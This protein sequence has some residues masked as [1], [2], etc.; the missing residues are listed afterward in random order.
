MFFDTKELE[1]VNIF[2]KGKVYRNSSVQ[3]LVEQ[4]LIRQEGKLNHA[5]ALAVKTGRYT[6]RAAKAR[7][8]VE[9]KHKNE[10]NWGKI[11]K[12]ISEKVFD[13]LYQK[14]AKHLSERDALFV[15]D[16]YAGADRS[17]SINVR[18]INEIAAQ[19]LCARN[20]FL[21]Y[22]RE[23]LEN[24]EPDFTLLV[25]PSCKADPNIDGVDTNAF[26][27]INLS[28]K[29]IL[30]GGTAYAGEMK[31]SIF[32]VMNY[33]MPKKE[34]LPMHCAANM[35]H[36]GNVAL[37]FGL[38]GTGKTTLSTDENRKLIGDDEHGW[39]DDGV[40]NFEGG[41]YAKCYKL[42]E[43]YEPQIYNAIRFGSVIE[44]VI[45]NP[46]DRIFDF[47]DDNITENGR[48]SYPMEF[49]P[50]IEPSGK[51]G[52]PKTIIFLTADAFGV[53]PPVAKLDN[54]QA[55]YHFIS[56]YTSKLAG[57]ED[58]IIEPTAT[59]SQFFGAPFMP[60]HP[61]MY[62]DLFGRYLK[63]YKPDVYLI[64]TGWTG[65][66]FGTGKRISIKDTRAIVTAALNGELH[67]AGYQ[68]H[69]I[70][71][72]NIPT[73]CPNV[74]AKILD[75]IN[76]WADKSAYQ[77]QANKLANL[78]VQ[79]IKNFDDIS[80]DIIKTGPQPTDKITDQISDDKKPQRDFVI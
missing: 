44:N 59:F 5:A 72:L 42:E 24:F 70:F 80:D 25:A 76:T 37:F 30:I 16:G 35:A 31:K 2:N 57:T 10:I 63:K 52:H 19:N 50:N 71:N 28:K 79:N 12:S 51:G 47:Y 20:M 14:V 9:D 6:G 53:L 3:Q 32:S 40:F 66:G 43:E 8:I 22:K 41:C 33:L 18:V 61:H 1:K 74:D 55:I 45:M 36:D 11:N 48:V 77:K 60:L 58:G 49:I 46:V 26:V 65:G 23:E 67:D 69:P 38:S 78:F 21:R 39:S 73:K 13:H 27:V 29:I 75:P 62:A 17:H 4:A 68:I 7:F 15:S 64:N 56:G 54:E 34:I